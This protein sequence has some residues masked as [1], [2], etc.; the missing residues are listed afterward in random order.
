MKCHLRILL[1]SG[2][3]Q[4]IHQP[5]DYLRLYAKSQRLFTGGMEIKHTQ[6]FSGRLKDIV[7]SSSRSQKKESNQTFMAS[8]HSFKTHL[9][10]FQLNSVHLSVRLILLCETYYFKFEFFIAKP[11]FLFVKIVLAYTMTQDI[12]VERFHMTSRRPFW[13]LKTM[14]RRPCIHTY[15]VYIHTLFVM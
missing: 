6:L 9:K 14:K 15:N 3:I 10:Q 2:S 11:I 1:V 13:C 8:N 12:S 4:C 5:N 7:S